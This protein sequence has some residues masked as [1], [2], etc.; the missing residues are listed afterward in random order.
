MT[1]CGVAPSSWSTPMRSWSWG[2]WVAA[3][4]RDAPANQGLRRASYGSA[5]MQ[6]FFRLASQH[7]TT[8]T[9]TMTASGYTSTPK[10]TSGWE[11]CGAASSWQAISRPSPVPP[12]FVESSSVECL[13]SHGTA[14]LPCQGGTGARGGLHVAGQDSTQPVEGSGLG[15]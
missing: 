11:A 7:Q 14:A 13:G 10:G 2:S 15:R 8:T 12:S 5:T 3:G 1:A 4:A 9:T 6:R